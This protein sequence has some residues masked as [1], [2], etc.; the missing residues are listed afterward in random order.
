MESSD[1]NPCP[2]RGF[3][4]VTLQYLQLPST[5]L[6]LLTLPSSL[7]AALSSPLICDFLLL[8]FPCAALLACQCYKAGTCPL[9]SLT[10]PKPSSGCIAGCSCPAGS[11]FP[12]LYYGTVQHQG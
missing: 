10:C 8:V 11:A 7:A 1:T 5:W 4:L 6:S 9:S 3:A 12:E 2:S